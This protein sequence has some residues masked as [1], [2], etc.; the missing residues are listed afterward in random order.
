MI[1]CKGKMIEWWFGYLQNTE[2][3]LVVASPRSRLLRMPGRAA[4][5]AVMS[6]AP[7]S[8]TEYFGGGPTLL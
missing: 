5:L 8:F 3:Y 2:H 4:A 6:R 7:T 1:G